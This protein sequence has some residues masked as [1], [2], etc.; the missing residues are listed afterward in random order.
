[1]REEIFLSRGIALIPIQVVECRSRLN[2]S[3]GEHIFDVRAIRLSVDYALHF[4]MRS[5]KKSPLHLGKKYFQLSEIHSYIELFLKEV[6]K[7]PTASCIFL[8]SRLYVWSVRACFRLPFS[9]TMAHFLLKSL[10]NITS[11]CF[12]ILIHATYYRARKKVLVQGISTRPFP[13]CE[14]TAGKLRQ[15][16]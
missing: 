16:R 6:C 11:T 7:R 4:N 9:M 10:T 14:N 5:W 15:K 3:E 12:W 13:G 2:S 1:M 8:Q